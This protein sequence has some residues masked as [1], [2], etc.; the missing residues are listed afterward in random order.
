MF[1]HDLKISFRRLCRQPLYSVINILWLTIAL[2]FILIVSLFI[3]HEFSYDKFHE[4]TKRLYRLTTAYTGKEGNLVTVGS[5]GQVQGPAFK[6]AV[7][8][9]DDYVRI[10]AVGF[11]VKNEKKALTLQGL[12]ADKQFLNLFSFPLLHGH[13]PTAFEQPDAVL[14]TRKAALKFFG[15]TDVVGQAMDVEHGSFSKS[16]RITGIL[17]DLPQHSSIQFEV[18]V[19]F[20]Y[21]QES[22]VD[23]DWRSEYLS[24]F[25][26][27]N[28]NADPHA[29][30]A[31]FNAVF[32]S[33]AGSQ[34]R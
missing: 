19:P 2:A 18:L 24:T 14:L 31:K 12:F 7:P 20:S 17:N 8:G 6:A 22:W 10:F 30:A 32:L 33:E 16:F 28:P 26:L 15:K 1:G 13:A 29:M 34:L 21:L 4:H 27:L 3:R 25:F 11:N 23:K 9:I 5:S